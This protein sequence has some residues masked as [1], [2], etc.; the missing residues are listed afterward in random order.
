MAATWEFSYSPP[1]LRQMRCDKCCYW[2]ERVHALAECSAVLSIDWITRWPTVKAKFMRLWPAPLLLLLRHIIDA[3]GVEFVLVYPIFYQLVGS[4]PCNRLSAVIHILHTVICRQKYQMCVL[5]STCDTHKSPTWSNKNKIR[6]KKEDT[7]FLTL[8]L[9]CELLSSRKLCSSNISV[10][11]SNS[12]ISSF[13]CGE[14]YRKPAMERTTRWKCPRNI[15]ALLTR[16]KSSLVQLYL[17][18]STKRPIKVKNNVLKF[19]RVFIS[20]IMQNGQIKHY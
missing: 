15:L 20:N 2:C 12:I 10:Q 19:C 1:S 8:L 13:E 3:F 17:V 4:D 11:C 6:D 9:L 16:T 5:H 14:R 18:L 7:W